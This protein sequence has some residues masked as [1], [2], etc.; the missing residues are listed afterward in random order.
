VFGDAKQGSLLR[1]MAA[2][3]F[4]AKSF[5]ITIILNQLL[6]AMRSAS[7]GR[8]GHLAAVAGGSLVMGA[9]AIQV[10][11]IITGKEP[12]DVDNGAFWMAAFLQGGGAGLFGDFMFQDYNRFGQSI[13]GTLAGPIVG[14]AQSLMKA[15]DLYGLAEGDWTPREFASDVFKV[16]AREVPGINLWYSRLLIERTMLDQ[17][18]KMIDPKYDAR[19]RRL[20]KKMK[21]DYGQKYWWRKGELT[22]EAMQR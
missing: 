18:E 11:Q 8:F 15:G 6:P 13:G 21:K 14:T 7:Q 1:L 10:R 2:N 12:R 16:G 22:P 17:V 5:P 19:M 20:E 4:F 3:V 9:L